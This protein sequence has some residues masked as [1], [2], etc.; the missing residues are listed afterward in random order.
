MLPL[1][2]HHLKNAYLHLNIRNNNKVLFIGLFWELQGLATILGNNLAIFGEKREGGRD[3]GVRSMEGEWQ[4]EKT[5]KR[6]CERKKLP[7]I[8]FRSDNSWPAKSILASL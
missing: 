2:K 1:I 6:V 8:L 4:G 5:Y 3:K 7:L